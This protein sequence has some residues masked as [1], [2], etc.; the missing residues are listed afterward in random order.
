M[1]RFGVAQEYNAKKTN[2]RVGS[3]F[4]RSKLELWQI[5]G[6][7]YIWT[8]SA[9]KSCGLSVKDSTVNHTFN[10]VDPATG[11]TTNRVEAMWQ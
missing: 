3:F 11:V 4:E 1:G 5:L 9:G 8:C 2:I 10:F 7:M 6:I